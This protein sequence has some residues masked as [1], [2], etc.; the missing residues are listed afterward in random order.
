MNTEQNHFVIQKLPT[1]NLLA[2]FAHR[3]A[4]IQFGVFFSWR[5]GY[6]MCGAKFFAEKESGTKG[7]E[8]VT[9]RIG[10]END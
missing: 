8:C 9:L 4:L 10:V 3:D 5:G 2:F 1:Y 7:P 6:G